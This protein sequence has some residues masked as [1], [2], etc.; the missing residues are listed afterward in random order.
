MLW[1]G[2]WRPVERMI[3]ANNEQ[4]TVAVRAT[5]AVL[6]MAHAYYIAVA[7]HSADLIENADYRTSE[8]E[9]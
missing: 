6:Y 4:T 8:W 2:E 1:A 9:H 7:V 3:D 5:K